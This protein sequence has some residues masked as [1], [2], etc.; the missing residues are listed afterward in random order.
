MAIREMRF[1]V[2]GT[3]VDLHAPLIYMWEVADK[4]G[5]VIY[6]YI[7]KSNRGAK[8]PLQEYPRNIRNLLTGRPYRKGNPRGYRKVHCQLANAVYTGDRITLKF[9]CNI[10]HG[11]NGYVLERLMQRKYGC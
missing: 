11:M 7:G 6:R 3:P 10:P 4:K 1:E 2:T 5:E 9:L 8:R